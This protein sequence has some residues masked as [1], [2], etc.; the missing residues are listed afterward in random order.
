MDPLLRI[1][2]L[3]CLFPCRFLFRDSKLLNIERLSS[4]PKI[5][6]H[7][8]ILRKYRNLTDTK[9]FYSPRMKQNC[10]FLWLTQKK[11]FAS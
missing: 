10:R 3:L 4:K 2:K 11:R 5:N 8:F 1:L 7:D 6:R 9:I